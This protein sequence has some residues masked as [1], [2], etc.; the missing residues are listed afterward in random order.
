MNI[1]VVGAGY[2]GLV[3]AACLAEMGHDVACVDIDES[4]IALLASGVAPLYEPG[5]DEVMAG[6][7][8][9]GRLRFA[10]PADAPAEYQRC[11][12]VFV[13]VG[14]PRLEDGDV[15]LHHVEEAVD[16]AAPHLRDG[17]VVVVKSTVP[18]GTTRDVAERLRRLRP[19]LEFFAAANPEFLRQGGAV[20]D[21]K[22]PDRLVIGVF[23]PEAETAL[24]QVFGSIATVVP[25]VVTTPESAELVKY[26]A[27]AFLAT[28]LSFVNEIADLCEVAGA[29]FEAVARGVGLDKRIGPTFLRAGP[30]FGG[31]CL[32]KDTRALLHTT[33]SFGNASRIVGAALA[34]NDER[35]HRM[36]GK[37]TE[38]VGM[39]LDD[40]VVAVLGI[41]F[42]AGTDDIRES[43]AVEIVAELAEAGARVRVFDPFGMP[44]AKAVLPPNVEFSVT[45][46]DA[47]TEADV[48]VVATE[49]PEFGRLDLGEVGRRMNRRVLVDLRNM[50]DPAAAK[51]AGFI[52]A[53]I[54]RK[55][56]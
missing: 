12:V 24:R 20:H 28:K 37:I 17:V 6:A 48:M 34:V 41:T 26:A 14:T 51:A 38:A 8:A 54:G 16:A 15:D 45:A 32:P 21:F 23:E 44:R 13:V 11:A 9:A 50:F 5:L 25:T 1:T 29:E 43:P 47:V 53:S 7:V 31:A 46:Y 3:T 55:T 22:H 18:V 42:K 27:N 36:V 40:L 4:K 39:P 10:T 49:W 33:R 19:D 56:D 35:I 52:Y 30:G 2:A